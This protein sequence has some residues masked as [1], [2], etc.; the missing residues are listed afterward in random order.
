[1]ETRS[2][3][4]TFNWNAWPAYPVVTSPTHYASNPTLNDGKIS[5]DWTGESGWISLTQVNGAAGSSRTDYF[6]SPWQHTDAT[7][8]RT[9][10]IPVTLIP[11]QDYVI[12]VMSMG[13][14]N[15]NA[16]SRMGS[17]TQ[18]GFSTGTLPSFSTGSGSLAGTPTGEW[19]DGTWSMV[20][21]EP[22]GTESNFQRVVTRENIPAPGLAAPLFSSVSVVDT[23]ADTSVSKRWFAKDDSGS[24]YLVRQGCGGPGVAAVDCFNPIPALVCESGATLGNQW[25]SGD[26]EAPTE[27]TSTNVTAPNALV[28][29]CVQLSVVWPGEGSEIWW[30]KPG[31]GLVE[32]QLTIGS[33]TTVFYRVPSAGQVAA[34]SVQ[35]NGGSHVGSVDVSITTTTSGATI[36]YTTDGTDPT[37]AS[38]AYIGAFSLTSDATVNARAY[39]NGLDA[40]E[41]TSA[42]FSI[43]APTYTLTV[44]DGT[45]ITAAGPYLAG[46]N[47]DVS[48]TLENGDQFLSWT[49]TGGSFANQNAAT[50]TFTMPAANAVIRAN[51]DAA[52]IP[53]I[54]TQFLN[55]VACTMADTTV[56]VTFAV[57]NDQGDEADIDGTVD[58]YR[59]T[60][61]SSG[62][63]KIGETEG[64][65]GAWIAGVNDTINGIAN[66]YWTPDA[67]TGTRDAFTV[68]AIDNEGALSDTAVQARVTVIGSADDVVSFNLSLA[69]GWTMCSIPITPTDADVATIF[70]NKRVWEWDGRRMR[71]AET[72]VA[73]RGYQV[74]RTASDDAAV[75]TIMGTIP[76]STQFTLSRGWHLL[77]STGCVPYPP[78]AIPLNNNTGSSGFTRYGRRL[79][80]V[81]GIAAG[82]GVW[83]QILQNATVVELAAP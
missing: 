37:E 30:F 14:G 20:R 17:I 33:D 79:V 64:T 67:N 66:A 68:K 27:L 60:A 9:Y 35:P 62:I 4:A 80:R 69:K 8:T 43:E 41:I 83:V 59:V 15:G 18:V 16:D 73:G 78:L 58:G 39:A 53:P 77:G 70:G 38:T 54:L 25:Y 12:E 40:S 75:L 32:R 26:Y 46:T 48:A 28:D 19:V 1:M 6:E 5:V 42:I 55:V 63:L 52:N 81:D 44:I 47:V 49:S 61:V 11:D 10:E 82:S 51:I 71:R 34:P 22:D 50:T 45:D 24:L 72:I 29:G 13:N 56:E 74:Y 57:L 31:L 3:D 65:A 21:R 76:Q 23:F 2:Q 7:V 36:Y